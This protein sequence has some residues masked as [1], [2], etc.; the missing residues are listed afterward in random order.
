MANFC[1]LYAD[2]STTL[3]ASSLNTVPAALDQAIS[4]GYTIKS[5]VALADT[6]VTLTAAQMLTGGIITAAPTAARNQQS[7]TAANIISAVSASVGRCFEFTIINTA[8]FDVTLTTNTGVTLVGNMVVNN[9][10]ATFIVLVTSGTTVSI[11][12]K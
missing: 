4:N 6:A 9:A 11:F 2:G 3:T 7:A 10:S 8:A 1:T 5:V 12:R